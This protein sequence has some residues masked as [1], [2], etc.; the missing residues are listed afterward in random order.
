[1]YG[2]SGNHVLVALARARDTAISG[3]PVIRTTPGKVSRTRIAEFEHSLIRERVIAGMAGAKA[4]GKHVGRRH[5]LKPS[6]RAEAVRL[7]LEGKS[8]GAIADMFDCGRSIVFRAVKGASLPLA[9]FGP[10]KSGNGAV[11]EAHSA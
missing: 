11:D 7:H 6:Q 9:V 2:I 4:R 1:M 10:E 8:L 5:T 3:Y